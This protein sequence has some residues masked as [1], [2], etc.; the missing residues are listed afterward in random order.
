MR[1]GILTF[2]RA[3]NY[4]AYLQ[5][6]ALAKA[7]M[8]QMKDCNVEI[9]DYDTKSAQHYYV[10]NIF[11][12]GKKTGWKIGFQVRK[13]FSF[14]KNLKKLPLS[15]DSCFTDNF[16]YLINKINGKYDVIVAG[17][18][19]IWK[20]NGFRGFP[21][22]YFLPGNLDGIKISYAASSRS[23]LN[24]F[25]EDTVRKLNELILDF[26]YIGVR[27][28]QTYKS[29]KGL[30][31]RINI[32]INCDPVFLYDFK[33]ELIDP[34]MVL[35]KKYHFSKNKPIIGF[36]T[37]NE[38][39]IELINKKFGNDAV[40]ISLFIPHKL[41]KNCSS[42][43][44]FEF[45]SIFSGLDY[46][47]T[48]YFHGLCFAIKNSIPFCAL[49]EKQGESLLTSKMRDLLEEVDLLDNYKRI[50]TEEYLDWIIANI[51]KEISNNEKKD[52]SRI[53]NNL[54][55]TSI[56]FFDTLKCINDDLQI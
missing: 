31:E 42:L 13:Y 2:H 38:K 49:E 35:K 39:V 34:E 55:E 14:K 9:I 11:K 26:K 5:S 37:H 4:G 1:I 51:E 8:E 54:K 33:N 25:D 3:I 21:N 53:L 41:T 36:M 52:N 10:K 22:A 24:E 20:L 16:S 32:H 23:N 30:N 44:P 43:S 40:L 15:N 18:D 27:D 29:L 19:Q 45:A 47:V 28:H 7:I 6:Y 17:S 48:S 50:D 56:S 46:F 12:E